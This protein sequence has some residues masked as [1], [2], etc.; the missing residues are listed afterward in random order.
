ML[1]IYIYKKIEGVEHIH[2]LDFY[3]GQRDF[4]V[5]R[6]GDEAI[7]LL[8]KQF[9][10]MVNNP[11]EADYF[12]IPHN[13]FSLK[14]KSY[15]DSFIDLSKKYNKKIIV[16]SYGDISEKI[17]IPNSI[18]FRSSLYKSEMQINEVVMPAIADDLLSDRPITFLSKSSIP[19]VGFCGWADFHNSWLK[20]KQYTKS[21]GLILGNPAKRKGILFRMEVLSKLAKSN[22]VISNFIIR[23]TFTGNEK[24]RKGKFED[25]RREFINNILESDFSLAIKGDGNFSIRF[26]E[27]LSLTRIPLFID[28]DSTLP[29]EDKINYNDFMLRVDYKNIKNI[30][31]IVSDFYNKISSGDFIAMQKKAREA[32]ENYLRID[33]FFDY[34]FTQ[35]FLKKYD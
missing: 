10:N 27:T 11:L 13:Y 1:N 26:Y 21:I 3:L 7:K 6:S 8:N 18:I 14:D 9:F 35:D 16:F 33:R 15:I 5:K 2:I 19:K 31:K 22:S 25:L 17:N 4:G 20:L 24:T 32:F 28:T 29:L 23:D 12:L 34:V 30:D